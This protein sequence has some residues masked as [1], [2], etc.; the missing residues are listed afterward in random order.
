MVDETPKLFRILFCLNPDII[1]FIGRTYKTYKDSLTHDG[2]VD[3]LLF[4]GCSD[5]HRPSTVSTTKVFCV[6]D[7]TRKKTLEIF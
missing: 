7:N 6:M 1:S 5:S 4:G 2:E 3:I